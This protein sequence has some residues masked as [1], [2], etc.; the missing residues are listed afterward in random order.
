LLGL[1]QLQLV[2]G[3]GS[4]SQLLQLL[5]LLER[6]LHRALSLHLNSSSSSSIHNLL[7]CCQVAAC[8]PS[9]HSSPGSTRCMP[10]QRAGTPHGAYTT[11]SCCQVQE[12]GA[13]R[14]QQAAYVSHPPA[15]AAAEPL[16]LQRLSLL[17]LLLLL[18][19]QGLCLLQLGQLCSL[20]LLLLLLLLARLTR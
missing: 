17:L 8:L 20:L 9:C 5:Q 4:R 15:E 1:E 18:Q 10:Q 13:C 11:S 16:L 3:Q 7:C 14:A 12:C 2:G 19:V 6:L